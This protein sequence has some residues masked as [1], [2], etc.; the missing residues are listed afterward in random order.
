[1]YDKAAAL[2]DGQLALRL[3]VPDRHQPATT[4]GRSGSTA[5]S[6]RCRFRRSRHLGREPERPRPVR[7]DD[8]EPRPRE[9]HRHGDELVQ[10]ALN[11]VV[12]T[13][14]ELFSARSAS[15]PTKGVGA[16]V[17]S[18]FTQRGSYETANVL[19][20]EFGLD[21]N[22]F[23]RAQPVGELPRHR[24]GRLDGESQRDQRSGLLHADHQADGD[25][26]AA[27]RRRAGGPDR[28]LRLEGCADPEGLRPRQ[29]GPVQEAFFRATVRSGLRGRARSARPHD[30][31]HGARRAVVPPSVLYRWATRS[32]ST[33]STSTRTPSAAGTAA[34][35][36]AW[37]LR[38]R[39]QFWFRATYQL[40]WVDDEDDSL[41]RPRRV[42]AGRQP[43]FAAPRRPRST[44]SPPARC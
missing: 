28:E 40:N 5:R 41:S 1:M 20:G 25:R 26:P 4:T 30:D 32:C 23:I 13:E 34:T 39:D 31:R 43:G 11:S 16:P 2:Q 8:A 44:R 38:D 42:R 7:D 3:Q 21:H 27:R 12:R 14:I 37:G 18:G 10:R 22:F 19:R 35:R 17:N 24:V 36:R 9:R 33:S 29:P 6:S 15:S